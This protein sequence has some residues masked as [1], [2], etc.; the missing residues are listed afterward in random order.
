MKKT[1]VYY[2]NDLGERFDFNSDDAKVGFQSIEGLDGCSVNE[3]TSQGYRQ[4]GNTLEFLQL[5][6]RTV[7]ITFWFD[8]KDHTEYLKYRRDFFNVFKPL[9]E[10]TLYYQDEVFDVL[11]K[12]HVEDA[13]EIENDDTLTTGVGTVTLVANDPILYD[14]VVSVEEIATWTGGFRT[15]PQN[16][17][18]KIPKL[19]LR[20]RGDR[21]IVINNDGQVPVPIEVF[22]DGPATNPRLYNTTTG[23][24]MFLSGTIES[25]QRVTIT[26]GYRNKSVKI[27]DGVNIRGGEYMLEDSSTFFW[28]T[29]G[30]NKLTFSTTDD[31]TVTDVRI[32]YQRG[33]YSI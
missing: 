6:E 30:E 14:R 1:K 22:F 13:P 25:N 33:Y 3:I 26:T 32:K 10:G 23:E 8:C 4:H 15:W 28:L 18:F 21:S 5:E 11:L 9:V 17:E 12:C 2:I 20:Q 29:T 16:G 24:F 19:Q 31:E 7:E 27:F